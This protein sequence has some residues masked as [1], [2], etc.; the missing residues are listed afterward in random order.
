MRYMGSKGRIAKYILPVILKDRK[1]DQWF[2]EP[3]CGGC[4]ITDKVTGPRIAADAM[5]EVIAMFKAMQ[6]GWLPPKY[7]TEEDYIRAKNGKNLVLRGYIGFGFSFGG[8]FFASQARHERIKGSYAS[9]TKMNKRVYASFIKQIPLLTDVTFLQADY[10]NLRIP[11]KSLVYCD[12]PYA[13]VE[14][15]KD[16]SNF[17]HNEFY[18][19]C[20]LQKASG[21]QIFIS[22]YH[23]P[24][25]FK[26]IFQKSHKVHL[27]ANFSSLDRTEKLF[28]L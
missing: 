27:N 11:L 4:N 16:K 24:K 21:H 6:Q 15:Y 28:T 17:N 9:L 18:D 1:L 25:D 13:S 8:K 22:E 12:P 26:C 3:F 10:K 20:R 2:V 7:V 23:M 14:G 19:W 5:P